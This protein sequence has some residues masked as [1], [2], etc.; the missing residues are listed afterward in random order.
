MDC[1][2]DFDGLEVF[3]T[4][5]SFDMPIQLYDTESGTAFEIPDNATFAAQ[6]NNQ[7]GNPIA[8]LS[9]VRV[10]DQE[11][12]KGYINVTF[13]GSTGDW[14]AGIAR[15]DIKMR[16]GAAIHTS[17]PITFKIRRSQTP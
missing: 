4:G 16:I 6:L 1:L 5:D 8:T 17:D 9:A 13:S 12:F 3:N 7:Y 11:N 10:P 2:D 14:P 15:T